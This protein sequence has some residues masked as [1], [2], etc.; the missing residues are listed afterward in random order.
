V[1]RRGLV[2]AALIAAALAGAPPSASARA[3]GTVRI[4]G[5]VT[6][7]PVVADLAFYYRRSVAHPP[8]FVLA[9]GGTQTAISDAARGIVDIGLAGRALEP[10]DPAGLVFKPFAI[11]GV[12]LVTNASNPIPGLTHAQVQDLVA[13][14]LTSWTQIPGSARTDAF[15]PVAPVQGTGERT[16]FEEVLV[17][18]A[19]P[20]L[21]QP[22]TFQ[23]IPQVREA[24]L[25]LPAGWGY[26]DL[27]DTRGLHV[28]PLDGVPCSRATVASGAY[29]A[30]RPLGFVTRGKPR[31]AAARFI[32]WARHDR[33]AQR[34]IRHSFVLARG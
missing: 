20:Q 33:L 22:R 7:L 30:R 34:V 17:D 12:C 5:S 29:P 4:D 14:R 28:V 18:P 1:V 27:A 13:G 6:M 8:R 23:S 9:G 26:V 24:L 3:A 25:T 19:T 10:G 21:Y 32:R 2:A 16:V 11:S 15:I 31:G